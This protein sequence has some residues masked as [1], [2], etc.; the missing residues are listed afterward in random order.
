MS[1][2]LEVAASANHVTDRLEKS[3]QIIRG[4]AAVIIGDHGGFRSVW[5]ITNEI[6][7]RWAAG[8][9]SAATLEGNQLI[10]HVA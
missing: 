9:R 4:I 6:C 2:I 1:P 5:E 7:D 8:T 3:E 10:Q